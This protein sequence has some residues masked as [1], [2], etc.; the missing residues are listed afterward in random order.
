MVPK[1]QGSGRHSE[2]L[3]NPKES[4]EQDQDFGR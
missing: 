1:K 4:G 2:G 3:P